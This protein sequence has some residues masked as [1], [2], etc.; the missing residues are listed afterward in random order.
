MKIIVA[1]LESG[2]NIQIV[3]D[4]DGKVDDD[5]GDGRLV[6]ASPAICPCHLD[7]D[8]CHSNRSSAEHDCTMGVLL[9][10]QMEPELWHNQDHFLYIGQ[11]NLLHIGQVA[12][13]DHR[14]VPRPCYSHRTVTVCGTISS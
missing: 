8:G 3:N 4:N 13:V 14:S 2:K 5:Y 9:V 1:K 11:R 12:S 7:L 6:G 10:G